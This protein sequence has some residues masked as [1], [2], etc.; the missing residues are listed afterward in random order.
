MS[1]CVISYLPIPS[2]STESFVN[3]VKSVSAFDVTRPSCFSF[4]VNVL[5]RGLLLLRCAALLP[6]HLGHGQQ[7][8]GA[9]RPRQGRPLV[10]TGRL[11]GGDPQ[12]AARHLPGPALLQ[13]AAHC[14]WTRPL[15]RPPSAPPTVFTNKH[16]LK[17]PA[18][19]ALC[20]GFFFVWVCARLCVCVCVHLLQVM[21]DVE[22]KNE[23]KECIDIGGVRL[24]T[25][26][27]FGAS[28]ATGDLS[29]ELAV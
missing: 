1:C 6:L 26:Y 21:V 29:G 17:A 7:R 28:A 25:G 8:L 10:G 9:V 23:W 5:I 2:T 15:S 20:L 3:V 18:Y 13:A 12:Q 24:P 27:F 11:L 16:I 4:S 19:V 14:R 22:G